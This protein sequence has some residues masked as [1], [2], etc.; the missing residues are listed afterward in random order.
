MALIEVRRE[1]VKAARSSSDCLYCGKPLGLR[2]FSGAKYCSDAHAQA[3][4]QELQRLMVARLRDS[5]AAFR[6]GLDGYNTLRYSPENVR[7]P[8]NS[9]DLLRTELGPDNGVVGG[10]LSLSR[11]QVYAYLTAGGG[12]GGGS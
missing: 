7:I 9:K 12:E 8:N 4:K 5:R 10:A 11:L 1:P 2:R 6:A 3:D